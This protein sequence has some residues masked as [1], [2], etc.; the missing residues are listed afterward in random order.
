M[1]YS[2]NTARHNH[3]TQIN[4]DLTNIKSGLSINLNLFFFRDQRALMAIDIDFANSAIN[5]SVTFNDNL[6][7]SNHI[8]VAFSSL[9]LAKSCLITL[10]CEIFSYY[11]GSDERRTLRAIFLREVVKITS[12]CLLILLI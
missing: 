3:V 1:M 8:G 2:F 7:W 10:V 4:D 11:Y 12:F 9:L 5:L 6:T